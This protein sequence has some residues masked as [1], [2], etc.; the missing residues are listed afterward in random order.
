[1]DA[2]DPLLAPI[3]G[4]QHTEL[5][6][7]QLDI[8]HTGNARV[9]RSIYPPGFHWARDIKPHVGTDACMHTHVGFLAR[10]HIHMEFQDG[11]TRDYVAPQVVVIEAG[12]DGRVVGSEPAVLIEFDFEDDTATRLGLPERH[13]HGKP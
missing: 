10:G 11:C 13:G 4:A 3:A 6:G 8:V 2:A 12:H 9:K 5:G 7:V 1:M